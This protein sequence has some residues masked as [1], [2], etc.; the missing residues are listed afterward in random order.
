MHQNIEKQSVS[1]SAF[2]KDVL[3]CSLG[4]FGGPEAHYGVFTDQMVT[5][6]AYLT[7]EDIV[8]LMALCAF[9]PGLMFS[10]SAYA[11]GLAVQN[12]TVFTQILG[13]IA[14]G[15]G[16]F[17][18]GVLLIFF[19]YPMWE[20]LKVIKGFRVALKGVTAVAGGLI[21]VAAVILTQQSGVTVLNLLVTLITV[22]LLYTKKVPVPV[23]IVAVLLLGF[24]L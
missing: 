23:I 6:K 5:K 20:N 14:G 10:F 11:G 16:I 18:P 3:I 8:E 24:F 17:L 15:I 4:A 2:L 12:A 13:A 22:V 1:R 7:E 21:A 19:V 9:S